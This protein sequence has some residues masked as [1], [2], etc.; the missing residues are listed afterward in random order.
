MEFDYSSLSNFYSFFVSDSS[1]LDEE[2]TSNIA[3]MTSWVGL[4]VIA[5]GAYSYSLETYSYSQR[6]YATSLDFSAKQLTTIDVSQNRELTHLDLSYNQ[7][8][9]IDV[10]QNR[11]L[12]YLNLWDN[13]LTEIDVSQNSA[14]RKLYLWNNQLTEIDVS[15]NRELRE[16]EISGNG[17]TTIDV[18]QNRELIYLNLYNN[19]LTELSDS[20]LSLS[21]RCQVFACNNLFTEEYIEAFQERLIQHR[22]HHPGQGPQVFFSI[23]DDELSQPVSLNEQLSL[24]SQEWNGSISTDSLDFLFSLPSEDQKKLAGFLHRLRDT[25]DYQNGGEDKENTI[26]RVEKLVQLANQNGQFLQEVLHLIDQAL[27]TCG[28]RVQLYFDEMEMAWHFHQSLSD[29][30]FRDL[31]IVAEKC[32]QLQLYAERQAEELRL[33]DAIE[34]IMYYR[35][36]LKDALSLPVSTK[37]MLYPGVSGVSDEML[38]EAQDAINSISDEELLKT[39]P[40]WQ[41]HLTIRYKEE[42]DRVTDQFGDLLERCEQYFMHPKDQKGY[43]KENPD[44]STL[45]QKA[46]SSGFL[47]DYAS[48]ARFINQEREAAIADLGRP[49]S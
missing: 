43:L 44:L 22:L 49:S 14:L 31:A 23:H 38:I 12:R 35:V 27:E 18:S 36:H 46:Y 11:E 16:L 34:T 4:G 40:R 28:D 33:G 47:M 41:K 29:K 39:S 1:Q 7:L 2:G 13:Q 21:S 20:I 8:R 24:W 37:N 30:A 32:R 25:K 48:V 5:L 10:S 6:L 3:M 45:L 26:V 17:L 42:T 9:A 19:R 15:Q